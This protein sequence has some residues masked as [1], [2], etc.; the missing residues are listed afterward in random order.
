MKKHQF[1]G[2]HITPLMQNTWFYIRDSSDFIENTKR[3][4]KISE[5]AIFVTADVVGL[6]PSMPNKEGPETLRKKL[7]K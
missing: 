3:I 6:Y 1:L 4:G 5:D 2:F 7:V